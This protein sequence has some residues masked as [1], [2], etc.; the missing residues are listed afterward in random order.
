[1]GTGGGLTTTTFDPLWMA[2]RV[3]E[4]GTEVSPEVLAASQDL[5]APFHER[6]PYP[7]VRLTRDLAYGAHPRHR[8]DVFEPVD[9]APGSRAVVLFAH[10]GGFVGGDKHR[11]GTPY[12]DNVALWA[13][14]HG[15]VGV[16]MTYRL[17]P[18]CPW[19]AGAEDVAAAVAWLRENIG[20]YGGDR[21][22]IQL[23]GTSAGA[24]HVASYLTHTAFQPAGG[25]GVAG[26]GLLS[27]AY[28]LPSF[29]PELLRAYF[30][31]DPSRYAERSSL[32]WL[33][34]AAVPVLF[35]VAEFDPPKS[36]RQALAVLQ[37]HSERHGHWPPFLLLPGHNHF[38][39][40]AHLNTPD[41]TL[42]N[43]LLRH[44][45]AGS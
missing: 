38:T 35:V 11:P 22:R 13:V 20:A 36:Q 16:T 8:L 18:E 44:F 37:A 26:A 4:L 10:G 41:D 2:R 42:G 25:V 34:D 14:R 29:D 24:V 43:W 23:L 19:P 30:G 28:H 15:F 5:Y 27:G 40:T 32:P 3:G 9:A 17:A 39:V 21:E 45:G 12:N 6:E 1:M 31:D 7:D 33:V